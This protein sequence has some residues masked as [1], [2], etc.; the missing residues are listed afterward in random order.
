[1]ISLTLPWPPSANRYWRH[2]SS[3]PLAGRHLI[4][5]EGRA[6]RSAVH[7]A[8]VEQLQRHPRLRQRLVVQ[9]E[10]AP[11]DNRA[12]DLDNLSKALMDALTHAGLWVDDSQIDDVRVLRRLPQPGGRIVLTVREAEPLQPLQVAA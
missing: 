6:Y 8:L 7:V 3:G 11:P 1:M 4:S 12:R 2:P 10:A 9:V 5:A